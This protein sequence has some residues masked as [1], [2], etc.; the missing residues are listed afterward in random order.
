MCNISISLKLAIVALKCFLEMQG[1]C[2]IG[3]LYCCYMKDDL[4][5]VN[6]KLLMLW[7][8]SDLI[9]LLM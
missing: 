3:M 6:Y 1:A 4:S 7:V 2:L 8:L 5:S 9:F